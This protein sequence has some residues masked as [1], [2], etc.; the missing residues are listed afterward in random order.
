MA[1]GRYIVVITAPDFNRVYLDLSAMIS[2]V[3]N[4]ETGRVA[5]T[6]YLAIDNA[7]VL[8]CEYSLAENAGSCGVGRLA[9][10]YTPDARVR[11]ILANHYFDLDAQKTVRH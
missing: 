7:P 8:E 6:L 4:L 3:Y 11:R 10:G 2:A 1:E 5:S 9:F